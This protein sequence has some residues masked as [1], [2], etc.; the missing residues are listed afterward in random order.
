MRLHL[1]IDAI[2]AKNK[3]TVGTR[4]MGFLVNEGDKLTP[5]LKTERQEYNKKHYGLSASQIEEIRLKLPPPSDCAIFSL[6]NIL[7]SKKQM[8]TIER[9][10]HLDKLEEALLAKI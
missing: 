7:S 9:I 2:T 4:K 10:T 8:S 5:A 6:D 3:Q 1:D